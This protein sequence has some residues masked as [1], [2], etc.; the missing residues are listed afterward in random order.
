MR[1]TENQVQVKIVLR[2]GVSEDLNCLL[3]EVEELKQLVWMKMGRGEMVCVVPDCKRVE[4]EEISYKKLYGS[5]GENVNM[6]VLQGY[7][8]VLTIST[9]FVTAVVTGETDRQICIR[10]CESGFLHCIKAYNCAKTFPLPI[11]K[12]CTKQRELC[13]A[14]CDK[15]YPT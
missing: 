6:T 11:P 13:L 10:M 15:R 3:M 12:A 5:D 8:Q 2:V 7:V 1:P 4:K 9:L 14:A